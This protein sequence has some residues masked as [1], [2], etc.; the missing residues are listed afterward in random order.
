MANRYDRG[1][2][3]ER[4]FEKFLQSQGWTTIRSAGSHGVVDIIAG[5]FTFNPLA[6]TKS[7]RRIVVQ[8]KSGKSKLKV[9]EKEA[10]LKDGVTFDATPMLAQRIG[11]IRKYWTLDTTNDAIVGEA[12]FAGG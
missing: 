2:D 3:W 5:R 1:A 9:Q 10:L 8:C 4:D 12:F 11:R 6:P 7:H